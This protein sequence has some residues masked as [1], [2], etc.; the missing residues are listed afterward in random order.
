MRE[1][2]DDQATG[3]VEMLEVA[4]RDRGSSPSEAMEGGPEFPKLYVHRDVFSELQAIQRS[5]VAPKFDL[6]DIG[7]SGI[8][9][10]AR[11]AQQRRAD[12]GAG[13]EGLSGSPSAS[14]R[15][16]GRATRQAFAPAHPF[17]RRAL[18]GGTTAVPTCRDAR[19]R[20]VRS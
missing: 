14:A 10:R 19:W 1:G 5:Q 13:D 12:Q 9:H 7:S 4:V 20:I 3:E 2:R 17:S 6:R 11:A 8:A 16:P 15:P 18:P